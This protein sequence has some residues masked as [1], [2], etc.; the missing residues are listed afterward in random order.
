ME[1][2]KYSQIKIGDILL[3]QGTPYGYAVMVVDL[4][5]NEQNEKIVLLAQSY[6]P[7]QEI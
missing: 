6:M 5:K 1:S 4:A 2:V 7:A 3:Q